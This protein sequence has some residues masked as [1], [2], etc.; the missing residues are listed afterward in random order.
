MKMWVLRWMLVCVLAPCFAAAASLPTIGGPAPAQHHPGKIIWADLVTSDLLAAEG[1]YTGLF[2]WT[3]ATQKSGSVDYAIALHDGRAIG[4]VLQK[5]IPAGEHRQPAWLTFIAVRDVDAVNRA[6]IDA[7]AKSLASPKSYPGRGRQAVLADPEGAVFAVLA[8]SSGDPPDVLVNEGEWI[9]TSLLVNDPQA[10]ADFYKK[11]FGYQVFDL[12]SEDGSVHELLA[13]EDYARVSVNSLPA[14][15]H[16]HPHWLNFVRV[17]D[18]AEAA[19]KAVTLGGRVLVAPFED[20]HGGKIAVV[21]DP[22]GAP[23]GVMEWAET[24]GNQGDVK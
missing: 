13:S 20:R 8:S 17:P 7:G 2:G 21:A 15:G 3:F 22:M 1:F 9:W 11:V 10:S 14:G 6:A 23:I 24:P 12:P 5:P 16:R 18:A 19:V 4:G